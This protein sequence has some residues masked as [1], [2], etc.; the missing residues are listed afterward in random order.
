SIPVDLT[1]SLTGDF[2]FLQLTETGPDTGVFVQDV[3]L[4]Q[5]VFGG[6]GDNQLEVSTGTTL[7][8]TYFA[9]PSGADSRAQ[10]T[11]VAARVNFIDDA[12][13][14][15]T[16]VLQDGLVRLRANSPDGNFS[17]GSIDLLPVEL[18][19]LFTGDVESFDLVETGFDTGVFEGSIPMDSG[20]F[21]SFNGIIASQ[22]SGPPAFQPDTLTARLNPFG[23]PGGL[24]VAEAAATVRTTAVRFVD[25]SGQD[26]T[27][28]VFGAALR[29]EVRDNLR[30]SPGFVDSFDVELRGLQS[31]DFETLFVVETGPDTGVYV[32]SM[33][34]EPGGSF[35]GRLSANPGEQ[36]EVRVISTDGSGTLRTD[37]AEI[38]EAQ[39]RFVDASGL[40]I[41]TVP[42][43]T[44]VRVQVLNPT[45]NFDPNSADLL[46]IQLFVSLSGDFETVDLVETGLDTGLF[47]AVVPLSIDPVNVGDGVLQT[48]QSF[49]APPTFDIVTAQTQDTF[50]NFLT[51]VVTLIAS[52]TTFVDAL[53]QPTDSYAQNRQAFVRVE[54][55]S[56]NN[57]GFLDAITIDLRAD[58]TGDQEQLSLQETGPDTGV[59]EGSIA[60]GDSFGGPFDGVLQGNL[61][62]TIRAT[63]FDPFSQTTS[64]DTATIVFGRIDFLDADDQPTD[65]VLQNAP[66]QLRAVSSTG[67]SSPGAID[68]VTAELRSLNT[69]DVEFVDLF[70]TGVDTGVF[71]GSIPMDDGGSGSFNGV[72]SSQSNV[73]PGLQADVLTAQ[74]GPFSPSDPDAVSTTATVR[75]G[76]VRF[77]DAMGQ[78]ATSFVFGTALHVEVRDSLRSSPGIV[79]VFDVELRSTQSGDFEQLFVVETGPDTGVFVG[80]MPIEPGGPGDGRLSVTLGETIEVRVLSGAGTEFLTDLATI[81]DAQIRFVDAAGQ[82]VDAVLETT[83]ARIQVVSPIQNVNSGGADLISVQLFVNLSGDA[84]FFDLVETGADTGV[85]EGAIALSNDPANS[86]DGVL[87]TSRQPGSPPTFDTVTAQIFDTFGN[88]LTDTVTTVATRTTFIDAS[89]QATDRYAQGRP[90]FIRVESPELNSPGFLDSVLVELRSDVQGDQEQLMLQETGTDTSVFEGTIQLVDFGGSFDG[91]LNAGVNETIRAIYV[92]PFTSIVTEATAQIDFGTV[93]FIDDAGS[94]TAE[95]LQNSPVRVRAIS[96]TSNVSPGVIDQVLVE[97]RSQNTGDAELFQL[98]ETGADT[99]VFEGSI[100]MDDGGSSPSNGVISSQSGVPPA[101]ANDV[102]TVHFGPFS[103]SDPDAVSAAATVRPGSIRFVD[104]NGQDA[105][106]FVFGASLR[107]E[108]R[109]SARNSPGI[110]DSFPIDLLS[111]QSGDFEQLLVV[112]T[113]PDTGVF[114]GSMPIEAGGPGDGR[115]SANLGE[116]IQARF[117]SFFG[118]PEELSDFATIV[119]TQIRFVDAAGLDVDVVL[120][121]DQARVRVLS[122]LRNGSPGSID[123]LPIELFVALT[124][125][126]EFVLLLET[127]VDTGV[128]EGVLALSTDPSNPGDG[129]LQTTQ[130]PGPPTTF[131][132][133]TAQVQD[134]FGQFLTDTVTT[135]ATRTTFVDASGQPTDRYP[136]GSQAFVRV[137]NPGQNSPGFVDSLP[138]EL[139]NDVAGDQESLLLQETGPDTGVFEGSI[140]L[141]EFGGSF[142]GTLLAGQNETIRAVYDDPFSGTTSSDTAQI[143]FG[144]IDFVDA[145]GSV[146]VDVIENAPVRLRAVSNANNFSPGTI[147]LTVAEIRSANS[148]D[149]EFVNLTETGPDTGIFEGSIPTDNSGSSGFDGVISTQSGIPP[150]FGRDVLT[151]TFGQFAPDDPDAVSTSA[152]V[153]GG[154]V[155]FVDASGADATTFVLDT[156]LHVEVRDA[157]RNTPGFVDAFDVELTSAQSGDVELLIVT[158]TGPDTGVFVGSMPIEAGGPGDG[159][160]SAVFDEAI[161]V[162][163]TSFDGSDTLTDVATVVDAQIRFVDAGGQNVDTVLEGGE[164]RVQ[165]ISPALNVDPF[166]SDMLSVELFVALSGDFEFVTLAETGS[167][168]GVF[169]AA[170]PLS[171]QPANSGDG[172]LQTTQ[173]PGPTPTFDT[174][175]AQFQSPFGSV[176]TDTVTTAAARTRFIG[177]GGSTVTTAAEGRTVRVEVEAFTVGAPGVVDV[178]NVDISNPSQGAFD[179]LL[180]TETGADTG[181]YRGALTVTTGPDGPGD[182]QIFA[183]QGDVVTA[184]YLDPFSSAAVSA[185]ITIT[186]PA[187]APEVLYVVRNASSLNSSDQA[188]L[189]RMTDDYGFSVTTLSETVAQ[190]ADANGR[191]L[192]I[193]S[194]TVNSNRVGNKFRLS[195]VPFLTW[196]SHLLDN[197]RMTGTARN[198]DYGST[199]GQTQVAIF[200]PTHPMAAGLR[201]LVTTTVIGQRYTWGVPGGDVQTVA[202]IATQPTRAALFGYDAGDAMVGLT[203]P[204]RR[205]GL[206]FNN[207][208]AQNNAPDGW[209]LF[210]A[211]VCWA[212]DC[213]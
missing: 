37:L 112:E 7:E 213:P 13:S 121:N 75:P 60:L 9:P 90:V 171:T 178:L 164:A 190:T 83:Q 61:G 189:D 152:T 62:A 14:V 16:E 51:D 194:S 191:D 5:G 65:A 79:D 196:E 139:F 166:A 84:E 128:F 100:P 76:A 45:Q 24:A 193:V 188:I 206:Y 141:V 18:T 10:A 56:Q 35:D 78:D 28:F 197:M 165:V 207:T 6:P 136:Q 127:G 49:S 12:G 145:D 104:A 73:P 177:V 163:F 109:D 67:N 133:I 187:S 27:S 99:G 134:T 212:I 25:A 186:S 174:I 1:A 119:D 132:T 54:N 71:E 69:G 167:D 74:F 105:A 19:S 48:L 156:S 129:V 87:Q 185:Q 26:A 106:S 183:F 85:F 31:G 195:P 34:I 92:D 11:V 172:V 101:F 50:G 66:I 146:T 153:R 138:V 102:L 82:D 124:S 97:V 158:E 179:S 53:G 117:F 81:V 88:F 8:A 122:P 184:A 111:P 181:R 115:L 107:V 192:I 68:Q 98:F 58:D 154:A 130:Q 205:V 47:E 175:T 208:V 159:R 162:R 137:E 150:S 77:V 116:Q 64:E 151:A 33:P 147:D 170:I 21:G 40:D 46:N 17:P 30:G 131:D 89:G 72:L 36:I 70:E 114:I 39:I 169:E 142:D 108:V 198:A 32:G 42:E 148:G 161:Q 173:V 80:S 200:D 157:V 95:V 38:V 160:L 23:P 103:P 91:S 20:G 96:T 86:N 118:G 143:V 202:T 144:L 63:T 140:P 155:R 180:L 55:A 59:F 123:S 3:L 15:I 125:D 113:G 168:T 93:D 209:L 2:E 204:A 199:N 149:V 4:T 120:E 29:V 211:A 41:A 52:R 182:G 201:G 210:D 126:F 43:A 135:V 203:A 110:V 57:P 22:N 94:V 44:E 176:L